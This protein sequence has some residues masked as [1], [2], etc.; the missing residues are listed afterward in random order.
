M[1]VNKRAKD[2]QFIDFC[3]FRQSS[4]F[5]YVTVMLLNR[6][7]AMTLTH[8]K[9]AATASN[10]DHHFQSHT[11][12][13]QQTKDTSSTKGPLHICDFRSA[14]FSQY[15]EIP[16]C[17]FFVF[18]WHKINHLFVFLFWVTFFVAYILGVYVC[19]FYY[20][21]GVNWCLCL[22]HG[23]FSSS[24][25]LHPKKPNKYLRWCSTCLSQSLSMLM[26]Y[27]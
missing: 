1:C 5:F 9:T 23:F 4:S 2:R 24:S 10:L 3:T 22:W 8:K 15:T 13:Q 14:S 16:L 17:V 20:I 27:T 18:L 19:I 25:S 6:L 7:L 11:I 12:S 21:P 26:Y